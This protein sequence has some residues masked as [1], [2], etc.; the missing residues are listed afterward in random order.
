MATLTL[1]NIRELKHIRKYQ[2]PSHSSRLRAPVDIFLPTIA[3]SMLDVTSDYPRLI[4]P[5]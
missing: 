4:C 5:P 3:F 1:V 2:V